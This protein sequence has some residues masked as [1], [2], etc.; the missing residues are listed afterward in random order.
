MQNTFNV[1]AQ[2]HSYKEVKL[3]SMWGV[4]AVDS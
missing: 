3:K 2:T 1:S 4:A